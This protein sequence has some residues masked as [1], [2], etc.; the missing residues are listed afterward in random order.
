V[1]GTSSLGL[2]G[3]GTSEQLNALR[4]RRTGGT[5]AQPW[6]CAHHPAS[7]H[8]PKEGARDTAHNPGAAHTTQWDCTY[9]LGA[10]VAPW[11]EITLL[12]THRCKTHTHTHNA[13]C[14]SNCHRAHCTK[15]GWTKSTDFN[16]ITTLHALFERSTEF[17]VLLNTTNLQLD[18]LFSHAYSVHCVA[19]ASTRKPPSTIFGQNHTHTVC[20]RQVWQGLI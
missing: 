16:T 2:A 3:G 17:D 14:P 6:G 20:M 8:A 19:H 7:M 1:C 4:L 12:C 13:G 18:I 11:R 10:V 9:K 5:A 15:K